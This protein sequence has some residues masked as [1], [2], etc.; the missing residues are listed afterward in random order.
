MIEHVALGVDIGG[1]NTAFGIVDK[2]GN[3]LFEESVS[4]K[5]FDLPE[6]LIAEIYNRVAETQW[7]ETILG[8]GIGAPNGNVFTGNIEFAPNLEWKGIIAIAELFEQQFHRPAV[9]ANDANAA[10]VGEHLFGCAKDLS[11]FVTITLGTGLGSGI[12][13]DGKLIV[14][15]Q[16]FAGEYGH[17]RVVNNGRLCGCGRHGCL[18]TYASST[19]V[20]R[21]I[22]EL[23][24]PNKKT[25]VLQ[26]GATAKEVFF[27]AEKGDVF[28]NEII[29][30]TAEILGSAL[31]DFAAFSNPQA[32]VL[33]GGLAQSGEKFAQRVKYY[34]EKNA[35]KI[36]QDT[37]EIRI[38]ALH[39]KNAAVL[40]TAASL[41]WK[42]INK[43]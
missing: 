43:H 26:E 37:I 38:S 24:S 16:G 28:A 21:S 36:F 5:K 42:S 22:T 6:Q 29:E 8:I 1:T 41:F 31:A 30:Y 13:I 20:V 15:H 3:V 25:S 34:L 18:E 12:F 2:Q 7:F 35:L 19:G 27:A 33:F 39:D 32:Y 10:A 23:D 14:G 17:I 40:G 11:D 4:T 9:L